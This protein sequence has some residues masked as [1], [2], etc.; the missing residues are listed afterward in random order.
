MIITFGSASGAKEKSTGKEMSKDDGQRMGF[1]VPT[2][3]APESSGC[4]L[5]RRKVEIETKD[6]IDNG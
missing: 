1:F 3:L 4:V 5:R 2:L 6:T